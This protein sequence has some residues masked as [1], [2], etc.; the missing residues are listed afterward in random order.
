[1]EIW[2][3]LLNGARLVICPPGL[4]SLDEL[5]LLIQAEGVTVMW[6]T[7]GLFNQMVSGPVDYLRG[8]RQLIAGG[9][10]LSPSHVRR[11]M[12]ALPETGLSNGYGPTECTVIC[13][14]HVI[15]A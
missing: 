7:A 6:L 2:A 12:K 8:V 15:D 13:C 3:T 9:E 14:S 10:A 5:G 1:M 4:P 11:A